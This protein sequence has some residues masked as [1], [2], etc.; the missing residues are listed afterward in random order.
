LAKFSVTANSAAML[1]AS[2]VEKLCS[3][4]SKMFAFLKKNADPLLSAH[5]AMHLSGGYTMS[6]T[7]GLSQIAT[8][9][10][11]AFATAFILGLI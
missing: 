9:L 4:Q 11:F 5:V 6:L 10:V 2:A 1:F 7:V 8:F 3:A